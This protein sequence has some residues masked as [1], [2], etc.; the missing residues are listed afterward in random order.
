MEFDWREVTGGATLRT[1][2]TVRRA[3]LPGFA[4]DVPY[5]LAVGELEEING[6]RL[7]MQLSCP[8]G[9]TLRRG[10]PLVVEVGPTAKGVALPTFRVGTS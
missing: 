7:T 4:A 9:T 10:L 8:E 3:F 2:T 1:W 6:L 5:V